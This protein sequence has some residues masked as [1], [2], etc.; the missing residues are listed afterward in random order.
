MKK[1]IVVVV[2]DSD[3]STTFMVVTSDDMAKWETGELNYPDMFAFANGRLRQY[4]Q[5]WPKVVDYVER[6]GGTIEDVVGAIAY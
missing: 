2:V 1:F 3:E 5:E 4:T 6:M